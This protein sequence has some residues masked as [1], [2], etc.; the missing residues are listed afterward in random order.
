M[1]AVIT[2]HID[3]FLFDHNDHA[4]SIVIV[5]P[6]DCFHDH[7]NYIPSFISYTNEYYEWKKQ[8]N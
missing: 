4:V 6:N 8:E 5:S 2:Y 3:T 1:D 7:P